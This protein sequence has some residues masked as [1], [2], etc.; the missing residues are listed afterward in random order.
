MPLYGSVARSHSPKIKFG[1]ALS[2]A[3]VGVKVAD[4]LSAGAA[5]ASPASSELRAPV[6][7]DDESEHATSARQR[8]SELTVG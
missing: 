2:G 4:A 5:A 7:H 6:V 1:G 8:L 3:G